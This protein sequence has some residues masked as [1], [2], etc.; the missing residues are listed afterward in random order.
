MKRNQPTRVHVL[1]LIAAHRI[2]QNVKN[3][4]E[5]PHIENHPKHRTGANPRHNST[6]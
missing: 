2:A 3:Q 5:T 1:R 6:Q 4:M